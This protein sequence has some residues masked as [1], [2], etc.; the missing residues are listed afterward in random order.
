MT[1]P[2]VHAA[3]SD[4]IK[5]ALVGCGGRGGGALMQA[6]ETKGAK[7]LVAVA[8]LQENKMQNIVK[9]A[10][11]KF[12]DRLDVKI[13]V[14]RDFMF[15]GFDGY[16]HAIDAVG[17]GGVVLLAT[18]P[19]F[20]P[21]H[22]EYAVEKGLHIFSEKS[23]GVDSPGIRR[24]LKAA[25]AAKQKNL[26]IVSGLMSRHVPGLQ[27]M[28]QRIHD[29]AIG[30]IVACWHWRMQ[31]SAVPSSQKQGETLL[32]YQLRNHSSFKWT[33]GSLF[34]D[35][36]VHDL[37]LCCWAKGSYPVSAQG[38]GGRQ[39][40]NAKCNQFDHCAIEYTFA[41]GTRMQAQAR[42][43]SNCW[44]KFCS[45]IHGSTG[46]ALMGSGS[47][48]KHPTLWKGY[49]TWNGNKAAG[50]NVIW[51]AEKNKFTGGYQEEHND[52]FESIRNDTPRNETEYS[53]YATLT[54]VM[55][56]LAFESGRVITWDEALNWEKSLCP[57]IDSITWDSQPPVLP[58]K[59]GNYPIVVP[60][61]TKAELI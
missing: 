53:C 35:N 37:D 26:K 24:I 12:K 6:L 7:K 54:G 9:A 36:C 41:D 11:E 3:G 25:E 27:E 50:E 31:G 56:R 19:N 15:A 44:N 43:M 33:N 4:E 39:T 17:P 52:L 20:R 55:G 40:R 22:F 38:M 28:M 30:E 14:P 1:A 61:E 10:A 51:Q 45:E 42:F 49:K 46:S 2:A 57:N 5:I 32:Q 8:D 16:K 58:D 29:G 48:R 18:W 13:D 21:P 23:F 34:L 59:D 60:G 47:G